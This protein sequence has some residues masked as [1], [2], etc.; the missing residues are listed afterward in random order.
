[1]HVTA[2]IGIEEHGEEH[3]G[4]IGRVHGAEPYFR[5]GRLTGEQRAEMVADEYAKL[6]AAPEARREFL[7]CRGLVLR[8]HL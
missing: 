2:R 5:T 7:V 8:M 1:M 3:A 6:F 4:I